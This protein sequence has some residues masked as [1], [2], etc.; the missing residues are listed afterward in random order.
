MPMTHSS[1]ALALEQ[2]R[3]L[4]ASAYQLEHAAIVLLE[5]DGLDANRF[6][7]YQ[8]LRRKAAVRY[9]EAIEH[10][11]LIQGTRSSPK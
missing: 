11:A 9:Q 5:G 7:H 10:L 1:Q 3:R 8:K 2:N 6:D 4:F